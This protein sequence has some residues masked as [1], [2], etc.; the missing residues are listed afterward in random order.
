VQRELVEEKNRRI[1]QLEAALAD[2]GMSVQPG[3]APAAATGNRIEGTITAVRSNLAQLNVGSADG[4]TKGTTF[5]LY[6]NGEYVDD[7]SV[8]DV[9]ANSSAGVL[10]NVRRTPQVGDKAST[11][12]Q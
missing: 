3:G 12:M 5:I 9:D 7:L 10:V 4:V 6:R 11:S 8:D 1:Q 2:G